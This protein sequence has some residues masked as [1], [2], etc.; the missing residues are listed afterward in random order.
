MRT[1]GVPACWYQLKNFEKSLPVTAAKHSTKASTVVAWPS[2]VSKYLSMPRR[3]SRSPTRSL[4][5]R[6]TSEPFS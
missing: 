4:S 5:I 6:M 2:Q 3:K 1:S